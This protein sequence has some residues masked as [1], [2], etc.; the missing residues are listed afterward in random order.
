MVN[1]ITV[2]IKPSVKAH[3]NIDFFSNYF[4]Q[5]NFMT[6]NFSQFFLEFISNYG[7]RFFLD[8]LARIITDKKSRFGSIGIEREREREK[9]VPDV[10]LPP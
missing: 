1:V 7:G 10:T 2:S 8:F 4:A 3:K 5:N 6:S 9:S